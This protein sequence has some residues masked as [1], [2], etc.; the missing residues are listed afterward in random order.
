MNA[1]WSDPA[2]ARVGGAQMIDRWTGVEGVWHAGLAEED[3]HRYRC[4]PAHLCGTDWSVSGGR[5]LALS[6]GLCLLALSDG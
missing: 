5:L 2:P 1:L 6:A 4:T 3:S